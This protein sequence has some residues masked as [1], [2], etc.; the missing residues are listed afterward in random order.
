M[1]EAYASFIAVRKYIARSQKRLTGANVF[2]SHTDKL[3]DDVNAVIW[4][5]GNLETWAVQSATVTVDGIDYTRATTVISV[6]GAD[7]RQTNVSV[8]YP[9]D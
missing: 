6:A 4:N 2:R 8:T 9:V 5:S 3:S 1:P 7:Y